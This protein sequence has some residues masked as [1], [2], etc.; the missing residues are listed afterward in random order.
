M[1]INKATEQLIKG[2]EAWRA[3]AYR[4]S[5]GVWTIGWGHTSKAGP[6]KVRAGMVISRAVGEEIFKRDIAVF[7]RIVTEAVKVSLNPNQFG[8]LVS[9][10]YNVGGP[11]FRNSSVLKR[12]NEKHF[13]K[14]PARLR[15]YNKVR[16]GGK[17][18]VSR[19]LA[20]RREAEIALFLKPVV[21][22]SPPP[23]D[24][25]TKVEPS[26]TKTPRAAIVALAGALV[27]AV[28][29]IVNWVFGG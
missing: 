13:A 3:K 14:V 12:V 15:L 21:Y 7:E 11:R 24:L 26:E 8:A 22:A 27:A 10:C 6:P 2:F 29:A 5:G 16:K 28:A 20:R 18:R 9:F 4:D 19:G 17:L 23:P 25:P 1:V